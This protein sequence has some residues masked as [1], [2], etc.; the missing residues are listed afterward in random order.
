MVEPRLDVSHSHTPKLVALAPR[1]NGGRLS[2]L[3]LPLLASQGEF[4]LRTAF[5][6]TAFCR[7]AR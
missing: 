3:G 1:L 7:R 4:L 6:R 2:D 5:C